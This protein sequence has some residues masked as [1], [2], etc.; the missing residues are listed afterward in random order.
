MP[1]FR[2]SV[3]GLEKVNRIPG[4]LDDAQRDFLEKAAEALA[5]QVGQAAPGGRSGTIGRSFQGRALTNTTAL[6]YSNH[7]GAKANEVGAYV[8]PG[9]GKKAIRFRDGRVRAWARIPALHYAKTALRTRS[10]VVNAV[11]ER[12]FGHLDL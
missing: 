2:I 11:Y 10:R 4:A 3:N 5:A 9:R 6:V 7:P 12:E 1:T 8:V